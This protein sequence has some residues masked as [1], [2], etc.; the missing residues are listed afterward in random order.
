MQVSTYIRNPVNKQITGLVATFNSLNDFEESLGLLLTLR[1][2]S[3]R[4]TGRGE[5]A[6]V[7]TIKDIYQRDRHG[8]EKVPRKLLGRVPVLDTQLLYQD[9]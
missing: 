6:A 9:L 1:S 5:P 7:P 4:R 2:L 3:H 8:K